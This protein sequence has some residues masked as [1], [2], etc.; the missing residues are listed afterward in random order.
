[1]TW[2]EEQ[3]KRAMHEMKQMRNQMSIGRS[4]YYIDDVH[5][6][7]GSAFS[8]MREERM[9]EEETNIF[10]DE[11][12]SK[13]KTM[14]SN[15]YRRIGKTHAMARV[16]VELALETGQPISVI[17]HNMIF[18]RDGYNRHSS[19]HMLSMIRTVIHEFEC[20]KGVNIRILD[21]H[22]QSIRLTFERHSAADVINNYH[23]TRIP[24]FE[25]QRLA[26][27]KKVETDLLLITCNIC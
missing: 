24:Y 19:H 23:K 27:K 8:V 12:M 13:L 20:E 17:D 21:F 10:D 22:P 3:E 1:M 4:P 11:F 15:N 5:M 14:F 16:L 6:S 2:Y 26:P 18:E 9:Y 7:D 25:P